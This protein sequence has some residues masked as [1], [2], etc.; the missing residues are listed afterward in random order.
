LPALQNKTFIFFRT[1]QRKY[2]KRVALTKAPKQIFKKL[3]TIVIGNV[4]VPVMLEIL[5]STSPYQGVHK[6]TLLIEFLV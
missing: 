2:K 1:V 5:V 6:S 3:T 4:P